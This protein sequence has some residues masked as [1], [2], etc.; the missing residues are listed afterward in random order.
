MLKSPDV[1]IRPLC[2]ADRHALG[3]AFER[4]GAESR[5]QRFLSATPRLTESQL[6]YL[7]EVD[8]RDHVALAAVDPTDGIVGVARSIRLEGADAEPAIAVVDDYQGR[9]L[10]T[11]LIAAL[12]DRSREQGVKRYCATVLADNAP[13][14]RLLRGIGEM[15]SSRAGTALQVTV[16]FPAS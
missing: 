5:Y 8:Q 7:T 1:L 2:A 15:R 14:L 16:D 4:M 3:T 9:G 13:M 12:V 6:R 11:E 10:G